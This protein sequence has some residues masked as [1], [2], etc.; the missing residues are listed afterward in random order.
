[1]FF[2]DFSQARRAAC[3]PLS[4]T[5]TAGMGGSIPDAED[6]VDMF[7]SLRPLTEGPV[8]IGLQVSIRSDRILFA[9]TEWLRARTPVLATLVPH[10]RDAD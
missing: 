5:A 7:A 10:V 8:F 4:M 2:G 3:S 1:M 6:D 9:C